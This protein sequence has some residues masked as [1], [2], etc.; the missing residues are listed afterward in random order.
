MTTL[1]AAAQ[2]QP[3]TTHTVRIAGIDPEIPGVSTYHLAFQDAAIAAEYAFRPGQFNML[4]LPGAGEVA[5]SLSADPASGA[6]WAHTIRA[7]G[8]VTRALGRLSVGATLGVR[9]PFGSS[10]PLN[11]AHGDDV[12]LIAGGLGLAPLRPVVHH[13]LNRRERYGRAVLLYGSRT[14]ETLCFAAQFDEWRRRGLEIEVTVDR[15]QAG[16]AGHVGAVSLLLDR[17]PLDSR[18]TWALVCGPE[19][20][21]QYAAQAALARGIESDHVW[22]SWERNMQCAVGLCGHCQWGPLFVCKDGPVFCYDQISPYLS[23]EGL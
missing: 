18:R 8:A 6:T 3:W 4:Y 11:A 22:V 13:L 17:V 21:M 1:L 12:L 5:I 15:P 2:A 20:M 7:A 19:V 10:W 23:I 9:G 14:P 16:W